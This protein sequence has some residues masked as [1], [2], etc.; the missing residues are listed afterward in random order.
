LEGDAKDKLTSI[1]AFGNIDRIIMNLPHSG[2]SYLPIAFKACKD[3]GL[4]HYYEF[5]TESFISE[6]KKSIQEHSNNEEL[7]I[8]I[9]NFRKV[10]SYSP[11]EILTVFDLKIHKNG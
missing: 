4:I 9:L 5:L 3:S 2:Y 10:H 1:D 8:E 11:S 6:R 7:E